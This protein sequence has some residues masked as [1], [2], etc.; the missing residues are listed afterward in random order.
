MA[1]GH[2][3][4][5][6]LDDSGQPW[7]VNPGAAGRDRTFGGASCLLLQASESDWHF[8]VLRYPIRRCRV[9]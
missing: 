6:V 8:S 2:S 3:H 9:R 7:V 4:K 5:W 1:Y